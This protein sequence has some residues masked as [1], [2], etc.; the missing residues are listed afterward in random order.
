M[1]IAAEYSFN[2]GDAIQKKC[3]HLLQEIED[4]ITS[5]NASEFKTKESKEKTMMGKMLYSPKALNHAFAQGFEPKGWEKKS[6]KCE[7][8][9]K[10]YRNGYVPKKVGK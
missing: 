1:I 2:G 8:S 5:V 6:V 4:V 3:S 9:T 10:Y 7:Y